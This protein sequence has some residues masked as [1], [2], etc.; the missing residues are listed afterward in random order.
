MPGKVRQFGSKGEKITC[1]YNDNEDIDG[2]NNECVGVENGG[3]ALVQ[4]SKVINHNTLI[5]GRMQTR[6]KTAKRKAMLK[7]HAKSSKASKCKGKK[8]ASCKRIKSCKMTK[9]KKRQFCRS[10]KN[11]KH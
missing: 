5:G 9:G 2:N 11:K 8:S 7:K 6:S 3:E 10:K 4:S 1:V